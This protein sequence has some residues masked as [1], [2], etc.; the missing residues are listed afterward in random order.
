M[1]SGVRHSYWFAGRPMLAQTLA[2][3]P[4]PLGGIRALR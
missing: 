1:H 3:A 4:E 2:Q